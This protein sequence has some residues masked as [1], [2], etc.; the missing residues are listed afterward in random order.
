MQLTGLVAASDGS[1]VIRDVTRGARTQG[2]QLGTAL[3]EA[4]LAR[5]AA[6]LLGIGPFDTDLLDKGHA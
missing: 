2:V 5:G 4:V 1:E 6:R 3:A